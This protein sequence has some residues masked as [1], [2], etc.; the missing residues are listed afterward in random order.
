M[1]LDV[2]HDEVKNAYARVTAAGAEAGYPVRG[3]VVS[4]M[5]APG[6][7]L[8]VG[9]RWDPQFGPPILVGAGGVTA[10]L[11]SD[12]RVDLA[13]VTI[14]RRVR[15]CGSLRTAPLLAGFRGDPPRDVEAAAELIT[16]VSRFAAEA[17]EVLAELD[18]NPLVVY[19]EGQGCLVSTR[20]DSGRR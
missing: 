15:C 9:T 3:A 11:P 10:E 1:E 17:G 19:P 6:A 12:V 18:V 5:A 20:P 13:P 16:G 4:P 14:E 8:I 2:G 7:E